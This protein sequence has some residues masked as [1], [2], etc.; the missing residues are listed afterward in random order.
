RRYY[1]PVEANTRVG[2][3]ERGYVLVHRSEQPTAS[4]GRIGWSL[5]V[6]QRVILAVTLSRFLEEPSGWFYFTWMP[7]YMKNYRDV[8]LMNIGFLLIIPFLTLDFG[9]VGGGWISSRLMK[10]GWT[11]DRAR[12]IVMLVS[13]IAMAASLA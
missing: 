5:L 4:A 11:L 12:K 8:P 1:A 13:A 10:K 7:I 3:E 6:R 9:K 2:E